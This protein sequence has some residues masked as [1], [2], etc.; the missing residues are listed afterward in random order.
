MIIKIHS[1]MHSYTDNNITIE[2]TYLYKNVTPMGCRPRMFHPT[3][4]TTAPNI[5][6]SFTP[7]PRL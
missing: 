7:E 5:N 4:E 2:S 6:G 1:G 3:I